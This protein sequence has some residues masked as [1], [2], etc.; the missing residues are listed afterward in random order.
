MNRIVFDKSVIVRDESLDFDD[1][2]NKFY[3][4]RYKDRLG[5]VKANYEDETF[6]TLRWRGQYDIDIDERRYADSF[7]G[8]KKS[9]FDKYLFNDF[10]EYFYQ[11]Y[12]LGNPNVKKPEI[13]F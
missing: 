10:C 1:D 9:K 11:K 13:D 7:N 6:I 4:Y 8:I 2:G 12:L 3:G 5:I